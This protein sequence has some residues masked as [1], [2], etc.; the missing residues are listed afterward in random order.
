MLQGIDALNSHLTQFK[1]WK[2]NDL[3]FSISFRNQFRYQWGNGLSAPFN[4]ISP[5]NAADVTRMRPPSKCSGRAHRAESLSL[6]LRS[7]GT[8]CGAIWFCH[9][10]FCHEVKGMPS[11]EWLIIKEGKTRKSPKF[12]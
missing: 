1:S 2:V 5:L 10:P 9:I 12:P 3:S 11:F 7:H 4:F 8:N 6:G